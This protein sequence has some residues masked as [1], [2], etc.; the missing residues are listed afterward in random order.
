[1]G[2][3][4][5]I[6][7][8]CPKCGASLVMMDGITLINCN[9]CNLSLEYNIETR[10]FEILGRNVEFA[11]GKVTKSVKTVSN[12]KGDTTIGTTRRYFPYMLFGIFTLGIGFII[13]MMKGL[14]DLEEH[15]TYGEVEK[16]AQPIMSQGETFLN[17]NQIMRNRI[18]YSPYYM[19]PLFLI[20]I[21]YDLISAA[22][23]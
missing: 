8:K 10:E 18:Y 13:Y 15:E 9:D 5:T 20:T 21:T 23:D 1:M 2:S 17:F 7:A 12:K 4:K 6:Y 16:G 14:R 19:I 11:N 3:E 22:E